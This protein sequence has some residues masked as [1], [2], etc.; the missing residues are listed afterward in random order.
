MIYLGSAK[1]RQHQFEHCYV[2]KDEFTNPYRNTM[3]GFS[4]FCSLPERSRCAVRHL[5]ILHPCMTLEFRRMWVPNAKGTAALLLRSNFG[6]KL[7]SSAVVLDHSFQCNLVFIATT[8]PRCFQYQ[9]ACASVF[10]HPALVAGRHVLRETTA[11]HFRCMNELHGV[12]IAKR[13]SQRCL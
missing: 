7:S 1:Y 9:K 2:S 3:F 8:T 13:C 12:D 11:E 4:V 6:P 5:L 10:A